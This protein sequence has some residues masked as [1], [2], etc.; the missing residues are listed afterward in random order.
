MPGPACND[1]LSQL[2]NVNNELQE[3]VKQR[4]AAVAESAKILAILEESNRKFEIERDALL[5]YIT[6]LKMS[7]RILEIKVIDLK[8][9][10]EPN[11][12]QHEGEGVVGA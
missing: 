12:I 2:A 11:G 9:S 8:K 1:L 6:D 3:M 7:I 10:T 5:F 4:D